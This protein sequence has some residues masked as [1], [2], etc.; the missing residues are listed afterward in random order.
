MASTGNVFPG[1]GANDAG[2]GATAWT[3]PGNIASD[4]GTDATCNAGASSQYLVAKNFGFAVPTGSAIDL[5][6][7]RFEASEH[8]AGSETINLRLQGDTGAL[9]GSTI[10]TSINGTTK[11]VYPVAASPAFW[12]ATLTPAIVNDAD[13]GVRLWFTTAHDVRIDYVT[14]AIDYTVAGAALSSVGTFISSARGTVSPEGSKALT[15]SAVTGSQGSVANGGSVTPLVGSAT[16]SAQG[17]LVRGSGLEIQSGQG[18]VGTAQPLTGLASTVGQGDLALDSEAPT[19]EEITGEVATLAQET[20]P[21]G[22]ILGLRSR[23]VGGGSAS[24]AVG[25][26]LMTSA[27]GLFTPVPS[28]TPTGHLIST[29]QGSMTKARTAAL[30]GSGSVV[31]SGYVSSG[32]SLTP[33]RVERTGLQYATLQQAH[34]AAISGDTIKV[35]AGNY[36]VSNSSSPGSTYILTSGVDVGVQLNTLTIEWE[37]VGSPAVID[38]SA[39]VIAANGSGGDLAGITMGAGC[40]NLTV[41]GLSIKGARNANY[42]DNAGI[43]ALPGYPLSGASGVVASLTVEYCKF[44]EFTNG[45]VTSHNFNFSIYLRYS[46]YQDCSATN[47]THGVYAGPTLL[48]DILGCTFRST[49]SAYAQ[50][51]VGHLLKSRAKTTTVRGSFFDG[52]YGCSRLMDI[53]NGGAFTCTGNVLMHYP[54]TLIDDESQAVR[55]GAEQNA[56]YR[57]GSPSYGGQGDNFVDDGRTHSVVFAQN[58]VR[59]VQTASGTTQKILQIDTVTNNGDVAM[60]VTQTVRGNIVA[61]NEATAFVSTYG[62]LNTSVLVAEIGSTGIYAGPIVAG[63]NAD[64]AYAYVGEITA[65]VSRTDTNRGGRITIPVPTW[66][67]STAWEWTNIA[68]TTFS[69]VWINDGAHTDGRG[70]TIPLNASELPGAGS[71]AYGQIWLYSGPAYSRT[72]KEFYLFGGGHDATTNNILIKFRM[73][74][75]TPD[76]IIASYATPYA[77]RN[78]DY[79]ASYLTLYHSDGKPKTSHTYRNLQYMDA[80]DELVNVLPVF[81]DATDYWSPNDATGYN[82]TWGFPRSSGI[83]QGGSGTYRAD[84]YWADPTVSGDSSN[85]G[86][87]ALCVT[88]PT[89]DSVYHLRGNGSVLRKLGASTRTWS[90]ATSAGMTWGYLAYGAICPTAGASGLMFCLNEGY[91]LANGYGS[92]YA[93]VVDLSTGGQSSVTVSGVTRSTIGLISGLEWIPQIGKYVGLYINAGTTAYSLVTFTPTNAGHTTMTAAVQ[94][95]TGTAPTD[96]GEIRRRMWYDVDYA[97]LMFVEDAVSPFKAVKVA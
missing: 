38:M 55:F 49:S 64:A 13:F 75:N 61:G 37:T 82:K 39:Y 56:F 17:Y 95:M 5:V 40:R 31:S 60:T 57:G 63:S 33:F 21:A 1:T 12:G 28:R 14:V 4:N 3:S 50:P 8:S 43:R 20:V 69:S 59:K 25:T 32:Q 73:G 65:P 52:A 79:Q 7:V 74:Q 87:D 68:G 70:V 53:S 77:T 91:H 76:Q 88:S 54:A 27:A 58:T 11:V 22:I 92:W 42:F 94:S 24:Y 72:R 80:V 93:Q 26:Q 6:T 19:E 23:K 10:A 62:G 44:I 18:S 71:P 15:G 81:G 85:A 86:N 16:T 2:I 66:V 34:D 48:L 9:I 47:L 41:R 29:A 89:G 36:S 67:P 35:A 97:C 51:L 30:F 90:A 46:T 83:D 96:A 45:L 84:G 78:T